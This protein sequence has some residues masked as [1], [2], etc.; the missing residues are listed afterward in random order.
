MRLA[1][2]TVVFVVLALFSGCAV[3]HV[4]PLKTENA[5]EA[6]VVADKISRNN[7]G[8]NN[9]KFSGTIDIKNDNESINA[10]TVMC[11]KPPFSFRIEALSPTGTPFF[12]MAGDQDTIYVQPDP[13]GQIF[14]SGAKGATLE[15][16][17]GIKI[18]VKDLISLLCGRSPE[19]SSEKIIDIIEDPKDKSIRNLISYEEDGTVIQRILI[20][21]KNII[22]GADTFDSSGNLVYEVRF[23][24]NKEVQ[25]FVLPA[26]IDVRAGQK[27]MKMTMRQVLPNTDVKADLFML[28][29]PSGG[30]N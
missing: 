26:R 28:T 19:I 7:Q 25:G 8:L 20:D 4:E 10:R 16:L 14:S 1:I 27:A 30:A 18:E 11:V 12:R 21:E 6:K 29:A 2:V 15:K 17:T 5:L 9:F 23:S 24:G 3:K 22:K 13:G